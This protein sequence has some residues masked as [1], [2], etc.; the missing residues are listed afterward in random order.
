MRF[1]TSPATAAPDGRLR[2]ELAAALLAAAAVAATAAV[3]L[4]LALDLGAVYLAGAAAAFAAVAWNALRG[5]RDHAHRRWG[6]A[7]RVTLGRG[8]L[9]ALVAGALALP[10]PDA[11]ALWLF[12]VMAVTALLL[13]GVDGWIARRQ[14]VASDYGARFDMGLDT[15]FT[16]VLALLLWRWGEVGPWALLIGLLR[17]LFVAAGWLWPALTAPL[18]FSQRRRVACAVSVGVLA[19]GLTPIVAPPL[20]GLAVGAALG[21][22]LFSFAVDTVWLARRSRRSAR[23]RNETQA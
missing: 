22:L 13:D 6:D 16:L 3:G 18:P 2:R 21:L 17:Y 23:T 11:A 19:V 4:T 9:V 14:D 1:A 20:T 5:L 15:L 10:A 7:N 8:V 12:S